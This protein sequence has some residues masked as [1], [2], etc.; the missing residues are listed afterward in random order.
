[1]RLLESVRGERDHALSEVAAL[2]VYFLLCDF[3]SKVDG[4][5]PGSQQVN[6][7]IGGVGRADASSRERASRA[8]PRAVGSRCFNGFSLS[9]SL[10]LTHTHTHPLSL[11]HTHKHMRLL[12]SV[13]GER[14]HALSEAAAV[15][16]YSSPSI[17]RSKVDAFVPGSRLVNF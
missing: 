6:L 15:T 7:R 16:V 11:T 1:M 17:F 13:R 4:F 5:V 2:T 3:R 10:S 14:D 9:L 12:E 8:R